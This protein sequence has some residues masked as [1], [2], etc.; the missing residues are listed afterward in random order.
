MRFFWAVKT[1]LPCCQPK[2]RNSQSW[3][4]KVILGEQNIHPDILPKKIVPI[5]PSEKGS[6]KN[7]FFI[8]SC[9][10]SQQ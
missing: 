6:E 8:S 4:L 7:D 1:S 3:L 2:M 5:V 9:L 10:G